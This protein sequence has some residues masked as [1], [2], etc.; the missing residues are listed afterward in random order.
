MES[1]SQSV[2]NLVEQA[3]GS[4]WFYLLLFS[5]IVVDAV[6]P[7]VPGETLV[8]AAAVFAGPQDLL[9]LFA[10]AAVAAF[11]GDHLAYLIGRTGGARLLGRLPFGGVRIAGWATRAL[12]ARGGTMLIAGRYLPGGRTAV[13]LTAGST[14][15]PLRRFAPFAGVAAVSWAL[16]SVAIGYLGGVTFD[17]DPIKGLLCGIG[18]A[19]GVTLLVELVRWLR[20]DRRPAPV[21]AEQQELVS[22]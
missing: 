14:G 1:I 7:M 11:L 2:A 20:R 19:L 6:L 9:L 4:P 18:M 10:V 12:A 17:R 21:P 8:V 5:C 22:V 15:F 3:A 16:Y 13:T